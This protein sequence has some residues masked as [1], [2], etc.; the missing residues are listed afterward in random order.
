MACGHVIDIQDK[1]G[2]KVSMARQG[3]GALMP[4]QE[5]GHNIGMVVGID[6]VG[7]EREQ[8]MAKESKAR[9]WHAHVQHAQ[10][11]S[12]GRL[13]RQLPSTCQAHA[14]QLQQLHL[15]QFG[16]GYV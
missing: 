16:Q 11:T 2:A 1:A 7:I 12:T 6:I 14:G 5:H 4:R 13:G 3:R 9:Q 8:C 10:Q 15:I